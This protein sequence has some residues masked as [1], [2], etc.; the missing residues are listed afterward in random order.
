VVRPICAALDAAHQAGFVH[1][2]LKLSNVGLTQAGGERV[3]KLLDFGVAKLLHPEPGEVGLTAAGTRLGTS[4]AMAPEQIRCETITPRTDVYA[5][6][7]I[8]FQLLTGTM[9]Y[10]ATDSE[11]LLQLH[12]DGPIPRPSRSAAVSPALDAVVM[13]CLEKLPAQR[14]PSAPAVLEALEEAVGGQ[15]RPAAKSSPEQG[16]LAFA[17]YVEA[18]LDP[19]LEGELD[20]ALVEDLAAIS[21]LAEQLLAPLGFSFPLQMS[22][23]VLGVKVLG[24]GGAARTEAALVAA[25]ARTVLE[26]LRKRPSADPR[27]H[28]NVAAHLD[29]ALVGAGGEVKGGPITRTDAWAPSTPADGPVVSAAL[30]QRL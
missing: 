20:D 5:L 1:R 21:D 15:A 24:P 9:P 6:G 19:T 4:L 2:D 14:Y 28:V 18:L 29:E 10:S 16:P 17:V 11:V 25:Q 23:A 26:K 13:R 12:L 22:N 27:L 3:V 8:L 30:T 7:V